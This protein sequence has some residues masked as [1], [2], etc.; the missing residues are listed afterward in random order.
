MS[1][2]LVYYIGVA[3]GKRSHAICA[4]A[5]NAEVRQSGIGL[6]INE[7]RGFVVLVAGGYWRVRTNVTG[8]KVRGRRR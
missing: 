6:K 4:E 5:I 2:I 3:R 8:K 1:T 7:F